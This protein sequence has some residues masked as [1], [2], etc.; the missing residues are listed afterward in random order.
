MRNRQLLLIFSAIAALSL[1]ACD[2]DDL[3]ATTD[4]AAESD[5]SAGDAGP[6]KDGGAGD[7]GNADS[8]VDGGNVDGGNVDGGDVDGGDAD[9]GDAGPDGAVFAT[10]EIACE[11]F[12]DCSAACSQNLAELCLGACQESQAAALNAIGNCSEA[13]AALDLAT[14]C[15]FH[16][17]LGE[18][19]DANHL[20][21]D[22]AECI[23]DHCRQQNIALGNECGTYQTCEDGLDC[24]DDHCRQYVALGDDCDDDHLCTAPATCIEDHCRQYVEL[25][26]ACNENNLCTAPASCIDDHCKEYVGLGETCND[27]YACQ[28]PTKCDSDSLCKHILGATCDSTPSCLSGLECAGGQCLEPGIGESCDETHPCQGSLQCEFGRCKAFVAANSYCDEKHVCSGPLQCSEGQ[29]KRPAGYLSGECSSSDEC[30]EGI[31]QKDAYGD[32][33]YC[34]L[35]VGESTSSAVACV[36]H[37][38]RNNLCALPFGGDCTQDEDCGREAS[39]VE[40]SCKKTLGYSEISENKC[41][42]S[43]ECPAGASCQKTLYGYGPF[44]HVDGGQVTTDVWSCV[45]WRTYEEDGAERCKYLSGGDCSEHPEICAGACEDGTCKKLGPNSGIC[46]DSSECAAGA[47]CQKRYDGQGPWCLLGGG[48]ETADSLNCT[49]VD[50]YYDNN[51]KE[52]CKYTEGG[53]CSVLSKICAGV[54][55][56][57]TCKKLASLSGYCSE[58]TECSTGATCQKNRFGEGP[59]CLLDGGEQTTSDGRC[60]SGETYE[61][62]GVQRCKYYTGGSCTDHPEICTGVCEEGSCKRLDTVSG[63]CSDSTECA[64][65]ASCQKNKYGNGPWCFYDD[66]YATTESWICASGATY[67][68]DGTIRCKSLLGGDCSENSNVCGG[69]CEESIC[70]RL[71]SDG[72]ICSDNTE[73]ATG[74]LCQKDYY[75]QGPWCLYDGGQEASR[76]CASG[77]TYDDHGTERCKSLPGA[78]CAR[79]PQSCVGLC[80]NGVCK[81]TPG[82]SGEICNDNSE[83]P[84]GTLCQLDQN[85]LGP[86]CLLADGEF[87]AGPG[88]C[89]SYVSHL[90]NGIPVCGSAE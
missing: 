58:S 64:T 28:S 61:E 24:V 32:G 18:T 90:D 37:S 13:I 74:T 56:G 59:Y 16:V 66:G 51:G 29:C 62:G 80:E 89:A 47:T 7:S 33:R 63:I 23:E 31:C 52:R 10:C 12:K 78:D 53:D 75:G 15:A 73:C 35:S 6:G 46:S 82:Y 71:G 48:Q 19:C 27:S 67:D 2:D 60:A 39:C 79:D 17:D 4:G 44:C 87:T 21:T 86:Y 25:G 34:F 85:G 5:G 76:N 36:S 55:E 70:K 57:G 9:G 88:D 45:S 49:S 14:Q 81:R 26:N 83:C 77:E 38:E 11:N 54:C 40:G 3:D 1:S 8:S 84:T 65:G 50:S 42:D 69:V 68:D 72:G 43:S 41:N 20:C 22:P 30:L